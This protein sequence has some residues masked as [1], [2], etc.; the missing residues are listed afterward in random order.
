MIRRRWAGPS[1]PGWLPHTRLPGWAG[2]AFATARPGHTQYMPAAAG[3]CHNSHTLAAKNGQAIEMTAGLAIGCQAV[4]RLGHVWIATAVTAAGLLPGYTQCW[5]FLPSFSCRHQLSVTFPFKVRE[6]IYDWDEET[7]WKR[8]SYI[9]YMNDLLFEHI[10]LLLFSLS[11]CVILNI[12]FTILYIYMPFSHYDILLPSCLS[13][14]AAKRRDGAAFPLLFERAAVAARRALSYFHCWG[15]LV[16]MFFRLMAQKRRKTWRW[17]P[18]PPTDI[19]ADIKINAPSY[20]HAWFRYVFHMSRHICLLAHI[21]YICLFSMEKETYFKQREEI[22][23][24]SSELLWYYCLHHCLM[25]CLLLSLSRHL[26]LM[27]S[28]HTRFSRLV[29]LPPTATTHHHTAVTGLLLC[30]WATYTTNCFS[31]FSPSACHTQG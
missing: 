11:E 22:Y 17:V 2:L 16:A 12:L 18:M 15:L 8:K 31:C 3:H 6:T 10:L 26:H 9:L 29:M 27:P 24:E 19:Y 7:F 5:L 4:R 25:S 14:D 20:I 30:H 1:L 21:L 23:D 28:I 13:R